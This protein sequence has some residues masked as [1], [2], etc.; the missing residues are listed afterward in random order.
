MEIS[1]TL[2]ALAVIFL[3]GLIWALI[4]QAYARLGEATELQLV[5]RA[6]LFDLAAYAV[7]YIL[8]S[9]TGARFSFEVVDSEL[10]HFN[11]SI[12]VDELIIGVLI[13]TIL[14]IIWLYVH[15]YKLVARFLQ[16]I[17]ATQ[18]F[19]DEDVWD[20]AFNSR[21]AASEYINLR[22]FN[23]R[24][25]YSGYVRAFSETPTLRELVLRDVQVHDFEGN[26]LFSMPQMYLAREPGDLHIEFPYSGSVK[27]PAGPVSSEI[28]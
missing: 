15:T 22:D 2:L 11:I 13:A 5:V 17:G 19:A 6:F 7:T 28:A 24:I 27:A 3:P 20:F 23:K 26:L 25:V 16:T 4:D 9:L 18:R 10:S 8:Y 14:S 12:F 21:D 1:T